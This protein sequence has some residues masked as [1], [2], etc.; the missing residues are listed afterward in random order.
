MSGYSWKDT[1]IDKQGYPEREWLC[2]W[3]QCEVQWAN[4][5]RL[6]FGLASPQKAALWGSDGLTWVLDAWSEAIVRCRMLIWKGNASQE[7]EP[8]TSSGCCHGAWLILQHAIQE[9]PGRLGIGCRGGGEMKSAQ[10]RHLTAWTVMLT[11]RGWQGSQE[12]NVV[13]SMSCVDKMKLN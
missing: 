12:K 1:H 11:R 4:R 13:F 8:I 7:R 3:G 5:Q 10:T 9:L 2:L 6:R